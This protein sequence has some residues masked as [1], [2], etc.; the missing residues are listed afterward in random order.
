MSNIEALTIELN[1]AREE[2]AALIAINQSLANEQMKLN[3]QVQEL[4]ECIKK[5]VEGN[6]REKFVNPDQKLL[7][8]PE[9]K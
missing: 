7:E 2:R 4:A 3:Q 5:L 8:F 6:R 1:K 9:D